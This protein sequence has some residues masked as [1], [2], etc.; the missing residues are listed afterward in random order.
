VIRTDAP[1]RPAEARHVTVYAR[2]DEFA[3]W[4]F[5]HGLWAFPDGEVLV[6]FSRGP[7]RYGDPY[8]VRHDVVDGLDGEYVTLRSGD[9]GRTWPREGLQILGNRRG[10]EQ[11][12]RA[13]QTAPGP[14]APLD[15]AAPE[16]C[17]T[18]GLAIPPRAA[19]HLGYV[20]YSRDRGRTWEGPYAVPSFGFTWVQPKP[21]FVVRPDGTA[22]LFVTVARGATDGR[23]GSR[24]VAVYASPDGGRTWAYLSAIISAAPDAFFTNRYYAAPALLPDGRIVAA[25]RCQIDGRHAWPEVYASDD[26]GRT[27]GYLSR[28]ADWGGPTHLLRLADGRLLAVYGRRVPPFG[29]RASLSEDGGCTWG[30]ELVLRDDGGSHDLGYPRAVQ[31]PDGRALV[32]YYF[33]RAD[34]PVQCHGGVRH[35]AATVFAP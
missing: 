13:G 16:F 30:R 26:G 20:Q 14:D 24:F 7:C 3:A 21:D 17:L 12:L 25:L 6:G 18:A 27:W 4:P 32:A 9:G 11:A 8:D 23:P 5:S 29:I 10:F 15:F 31:L 2:P 19:P 33:N 28:I 35:I 22:L 1:P 34:D